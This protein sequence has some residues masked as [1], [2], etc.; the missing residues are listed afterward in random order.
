MLW[1]D[2]EWNFYSSQIKFLWS[3]SLFIPFLLFAYSCSNKK[4]ILLVIKSDLDTTEVIHMEFLLGNILVNDTSI[5]SHPHFT[6]YTPLCLFFGDFFRNVTK[7][8]KFRNDTCFLSVMLWNLADHII[9]PFLTYGML[10]NLT[11][12]NRLLE[13]NFQITPKIKIVVQPPHKPSY[14]VH[15]VL[16]LVDCQELACL[17]MSQVLTD[18][19]CPGWVGIGQAWFWA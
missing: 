7:L 12:G 3:Y 18:W 11:N 6:K 10:R 5:C 15:F 16:L 4:L 17:G 2:L 14:F 9:I 19:L 8:Y 13:G 1:G